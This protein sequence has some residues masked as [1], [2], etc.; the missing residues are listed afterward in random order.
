[1]FV[2]CHD[3]PALAFDDVLP[4]C[5][6]DADVAAC[7]ARHADFTLPPPLL[8]LFITITP[9]CH[10]SLRLMHMLLYA[11]LPSGDDVIMPASDTASAADIDMLKWRRLLYNTACCRFAILM[12]R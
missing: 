7:H 12:P 11:S 3:A 5:L 10:F 4:C 8:P 2:R 9:P 1:M 6:M